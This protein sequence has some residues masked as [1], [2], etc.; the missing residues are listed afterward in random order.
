M[1]KTPAHLNSELKELL[2]ENPKHKIN[3]MSVIID[4]QTLTYVLEN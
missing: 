2:K 4:G 3:R 1:E